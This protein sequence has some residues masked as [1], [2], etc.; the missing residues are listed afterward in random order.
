MYLVIVE[1]CRTFEIVKIFENDHSTIPIY[2]MT[3]SSADLNSAEN[4][5]VQ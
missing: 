2:A 3:P 5:S 1:G 4:S